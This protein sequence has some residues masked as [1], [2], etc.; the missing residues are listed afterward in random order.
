MLTYNKHMFA[1]TRS[2]QSWISYSLFPETDFTVAFLQKVKSKTPWYQGNS[3]QPDWLQK[4][5]WAAQCTDTYKCSLMPSRRCRMSRD[6][7]SSRMREGTPMNNLMWNLK[8]QASAQ[9]P[10]YDFELGA[11]VK[12]DQ[13]MAHMQCME[14]NINLFDGT[15]N[16]GNRSFYDLKKIQIREQTKVYWDNDSIYK[17][18]CTYVYT[19]DMTIR[20]MTHRCE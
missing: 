14:R 13:V 15:R 7:P 10:S 20:D 16:L 18:R 5:E 4:S 3:H 9:A 17:L 12:C 2:S 11:N 8:L 6:N 19:V 1:L